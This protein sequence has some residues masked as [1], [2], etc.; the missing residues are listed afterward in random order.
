MYKLLSKPKHLTAAA[1]YTA[2]QIIELFGYVWKH[3]TR[4]MLKQQ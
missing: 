4:K 3:N 1:D 2:V